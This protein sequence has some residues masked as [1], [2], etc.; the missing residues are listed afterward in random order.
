MHRYRKLNRVKPSQQRVEGNLCLQPRERRT[1]AV[2]HALPK[3]EVRIGR[4]SQVKRLRFDLE[5]ADRGER[6]L[7]LPPWTSSSACTRRR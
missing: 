5:L 4:A 6:P 3:G 1:Q 2:V 7:Q